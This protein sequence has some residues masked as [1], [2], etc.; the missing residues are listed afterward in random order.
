MWVVVPLSAASRTLAKSVAMRQLTVPTNVR[1]I[2]SCTL[3]SAVLDAPRHAAIPGGS[4][5]FVSQPQSVRNIG[6][7]GIPNKSIDHPRGKESQEYKIRHRQMR[8]LYLGIVAAFAYAYY[9]T[10]RT[11]H[12][13][14]LMLSDR[15]RFMWGYGEEVPASYYERK[16]YAY[17][18]P[19]S[20]PLPRDDPLSQRAEE[21][22]MTMCRTNGIHRLRND[23]WVESNPSWGRKKKCSRGVL[24]FSKYL[25]E[26]ASTDEEFAAVIAKDLAHHML[27]HSYEQ[28]SMYTYWCVFGPISMWAG[29]GWPYYAWQKMVHQRKLTKEAIAVGRKFREN[30]NAAKEKGEVPDYKVDVFRGF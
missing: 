27:R 8:K 29:L 20:V 1:L 13:G 28:A 5:I 16:W 21:V 7:I 23:W 2:H 3:R 22:L 12:E 4:R 15:K 30:M 6:M 24:Q 9:M 18:N 25:L 10:R 17:H 19:Q 11:I 26:N 14:H